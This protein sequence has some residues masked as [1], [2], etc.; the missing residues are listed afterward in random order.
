MQ[1][2]FAA[3]GLAQK[4]RRRSMSVLLQAIA[5][6]AQ[7]TLVADK[8]PELKYEASCRAA[9]QTANMPGRDESA[10]LNDEKAAKEQL[11][12]DW[13]GFTAEQKVHCIALLR[14]GGMPSYVELLTCAEMGKAAS[15][16]PVGSGMVPSSKIER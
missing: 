4:D 1:F 6:G 15:N 5:V 7:L 8:V 14:A 11:Q 12:K 3:R 9:V 10:C 16:L 2:A 13:G